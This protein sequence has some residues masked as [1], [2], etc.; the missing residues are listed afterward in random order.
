MP[1]NPQR[2]EPFRLGFLTAIDLA[3]RGHVGGLL[4]TNHLGRPLEFQCTAPVKANRTQEI[5]YG[6]TLAPYVLCELIGATLLEKVG[7][8]PHLVLVDDERLLDLRE[9]VL[10]PVAC[11]PPAPDEKPTAGAGPQPI[12]VDAAGAAADTFPPMRLGRQRLRFHA[13]HSG[14]SRALEA[15]RPHV[16]GDADLCEPFTRV[17]EALRETMG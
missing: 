13:S 12:S 6:P 4:V 9:H 8:K 7:V 14:D 5:L 17:R 2:D 16:P 10:I 3:E 15:A 11:L 1:Q